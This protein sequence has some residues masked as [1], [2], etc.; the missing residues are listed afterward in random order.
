MRFARK[1]DKN[2]IGFWIKIVL[3]RIINDSEISFALCTLVWKHLVDLPRFQ[4]FAV[5]VS[6]AKRKPLFPLFFYHV[7][8]NLRNV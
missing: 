2:E 7:V 1:V 8:L 6:H 3:S 5:V 4:I